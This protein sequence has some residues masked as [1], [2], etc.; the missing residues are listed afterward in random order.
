MN[1][2]IT[3]CVASILLATANFTFADTYNGICLVRDGYTAAPN[4]ND[5]NISTGYAK[6][7]MGTVTDITDLRN[8]CTD[9]D[10]QRLM[11]GYCLYNLKDQRPV[12]WSVETFYQDGRLYQLGCAK[13]GCDYHT[14][15]QF[16]KKNFS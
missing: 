16:M 9:E 6:L 8:K 5:P 1:K 11:T 3:F 14:C 7:P 10:F 4:Y 2:H 12:Q 13:Q 15:S